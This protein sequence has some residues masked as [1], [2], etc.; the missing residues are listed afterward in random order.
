MLRLCEQEWCYGTLGD[1]K[2]LLFQL[3]T[4]FPSL[5]QKINEC[6]ATS[7][8]SFA[9]SSA[10]RIAHT[11][12]IEA[13]VAPYS[14]CSQVVSYTLFRP[15]LPISTSPLFCLRVHDAL[16]HTCQLIGKHDQVQHLLLRVNAGQ[17][18]LLGQ[19]S[20]M[21]AQVKCSKRCHGPSRR[22]CLNSAWS[23]DQSVE[24]ASA[25]ISVGVGLEK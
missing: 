2:T 12:S 7:L 18:A 8:A 24:S 21:K 15:K 4:L 20:C 23:Q 19:C 9:T 13:R 17:G 14:G 3:V 25:S 10:I 22:S 6:P 5:Y 16:Y 11:M 1:A